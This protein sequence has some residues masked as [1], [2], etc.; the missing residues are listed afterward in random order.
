MQYGRKN[1]HPARAAS[2]PQGEIIAL[3][4][5]GMLVSYASPCHQAVM[6]ACYTRPFQNYLPVYE[7]SSRPALPFCFHRLTPGVRQHGLRQPFPIPACN[8]GRRYRH[9]RLRHR[10]SRRQRPRRLARRQLRR[11]RMRQRPHHAVPEL[12]PGRAVLRHH[13]AGGTGRT[14]RSGRAAGHPA[15]ARPP[16]NTCMQHPRAR[17]I[18]R[19]ASLILTDFT[20]LHTWN[21]YLTRQSGSAC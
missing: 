6:R 7:T 16:L 14:C 13:L 3:T 4:I 10:L 5:Y 21:G 15:A 18:S 17:G 8:R 20:R 19:Q 2:S 1:A 12:A 11:R 9:A